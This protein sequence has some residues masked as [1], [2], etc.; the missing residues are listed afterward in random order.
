MIVTVVSCFAIDS[1]GG[2]GELTRYYDVIVSR[3]LIG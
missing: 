1:P 2:S 3:A